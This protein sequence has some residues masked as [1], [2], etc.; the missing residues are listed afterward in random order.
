MRLGRQN[1]AE[2]RLK[3]FVRRIEEMSRKDEDRRKEA[4]EIFALRLRAAAQLHAVCVRFVE[5]VNRLLPKPI[6]ELSPPEWS[7]AFFRDSAVNVF[8]LAL[9]G[10]I[11][12]LEFRA[13]ETLIST[14][15]FRVPYILEGAVR[16]FNQ[17]MLD[18]A[19]VPERLLFCCLERG[20]TSWLWFDPRTQRM[21]SLDEEHLIG[22]FERLL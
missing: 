3:R 22:L 15:K 13:P 2:D 20:Q 16:A 1:G 6:L 21:A 17:D 8:Q 7:D 14:E 4:Q 11:V 18:L 19:V 10:R 9:A 12:H 5:S